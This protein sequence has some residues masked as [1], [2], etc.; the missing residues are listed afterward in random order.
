[1]K[2]SKLKLLLTSAVALAGLGGLSQTAPVRVFANVTATSVWKLVSSS[3]FEGKETVIQHE[4]IAAESQK[5]LLN[6]TPTW[7]ART[8]EQTK[9]EIK[10]Q[11]ESG[12]SHYVIQWGDTLGVIALATE[13]DVNELAKVN[14]LSDKDKI[15]TGDVLQG[16][17][18]K[19]VTTATVAQAEVAQAE[20]QA[21]QNPVATTNPTVA[22]TPKEDKFIK[23]ADVKV[24]RESILKALNERTD[25][26]A[27]EKHLIS[28]GVGRTLNDAEGMHVPKGAIEKVKELV[29]NYKT[30]QNFDEFADQLRPFD[31]RL[32]GQ[33]QEAPQA[34]QG[35]FYTSEQ[36]DAQ[37]QAIFD[38][39][40]AR[41][42]LTDDEKQLI[43]IGV[44]RAIQGDKVKLDT[45]AKVKALVDA[46]QTGQNFDALADELVKYDTRYQNVPQEATPT[47]APEVPAQPEAPQ[48]EA[49]AV[50]TPTP[51]APAEQPAPTPEVPS[52]P[53]PAPT[54]EVPAEPAPTP[55]PEAPNTNGYPAVWGG[56]PYSHQSPNGYPAYG[57]RIFESFEAAQ[58][59]WLAGDPN[60][61]GFDA[62][63]A[64][65]YKSST[66]A[67]QSGQPSTGY[68]KVFYYGDVPKQ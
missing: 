68:V 60:V 12:L 62:Y 9:A 17:L 14:G 42:D 59:A 35:E 20:A 56:L 44:H 49:P 61:P 15:V 57:P 18:D 45:P 51:Q 37:R 32:Q 34:P 48:P 50:E 2:K 23:P 6:I 47:P 26:T 43:S 7:T 40:Y 19:N 8:L 39:L 58:N 64:D 24:A 63:F 16:V 38:A 3:S 54:P 11:K 13:Q 28:I 29:D 25:L 22:P 66:E 67:A 27:D 55:Q 53:A 65:D 1:M 46:F 4:S 33:A 41:T 31:P 30:G 36:A 52:E 10:R 5:A 21:T